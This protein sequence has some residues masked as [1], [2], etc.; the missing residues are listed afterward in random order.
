MSL[1]ALMKRNSHSLRGPKGSRGH[2]SPVDLTMSLNQVYI[3]HVGSRPTLIPLAMYL[4]VHR[5]LQHGLHKLLIRLN[6]LHMSHHLLFSCQ[7]Q[8]VSI[9]MLNLLLT[10]TA[11]V[12]PRVQAQL[13][14]HIHTLSQEP[15]SQGPHMLPTRIL[16]EL[17]ICLQ[18]LPL[19]PLEGS[20]IKLLQHLS[21]T[22]RSKDAE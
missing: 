5:H 15:Q 17:Y 3:L 4:N 19:R 20:P 7:I 18:M 13:P 8:D 12:T 6:T 21:F 22:Q 9:H 16:Q 1:L 11:D 2:T 14:R 10:P